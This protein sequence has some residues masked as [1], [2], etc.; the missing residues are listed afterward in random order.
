VILAHEIGHDGDG[1]MSLA[2]KVI[3]NMYLFKKLAYANILHKILD[4]IHIL[5]YVIPNMVWHWKLLECQN[6]MSSKREYNISAITKS[7]SIIN[8]IKENDGA[9][10]A[11]IYTD[12]SLPKSSTY[13]IIR[14]LMQ[15][16]ILIQEPDKRFHLGLKLFEFGQAS[17]ARLD[18]REISHPILHELADTT[19]LTV[20]F[21]ILNEQYDG[22]FIDRIDGKTYTFTHTKIGARIMLGASATGKALVAWQEKSVQQKIFANMKFKSASPFAIKN[23]EEYKRDCEKSV[24]RG[25]AIDNQE[26]IINIIGIG[27]PVFRYDNAPCAAI[28]IGGLLQDLDLSDCETQI[29]HTRKAAEKI[30]A[31]MGR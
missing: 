27:F 10:F 8:Y 28:A 24:R 17:I 26:S 16:D 13:Q 14:A 3:N 25:Y 9:L 19:N 12:L 31:L 21:G 11:D 1:Q 18:I 29:E 2:G 22:I 15:N 7:L 6:T 30:S 23:I 20:H 4:S 5:Q